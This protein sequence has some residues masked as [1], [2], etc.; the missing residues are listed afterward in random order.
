MSGLDVF[1]LIVL[2]VLVIV[3][4]AAWVILDMLPGRIARQRNHPQAEAINVCGWWGVLTM[5]LLLPLAYI[6]AYTRPRAD[7]QPPAAFQTRGR[8]R[9]SRDSASLPDR[10]PQTVS[11]SFAMV[12]SAMR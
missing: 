1:A 12:G 4:V 11:Q 9:A 6:W 8:G 10:P 5:G 2:C 7:P 3:A